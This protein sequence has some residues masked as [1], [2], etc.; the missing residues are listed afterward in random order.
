MTLRRISLS[1]KSM[2]LYLRGKI[3]EWLHVAHG[4]RLAQC[5]CKQDDKECGVRRCKEVGF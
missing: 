3:S 5:I 1:V 4:E 2:R